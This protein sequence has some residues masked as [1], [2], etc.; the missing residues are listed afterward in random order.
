V[1]DL[2]LEDLEVVGS[3]YTGE[4]NGAQ[5]EVNV[6]EAPL[7]DCDHLEIRRAH[8]DYQID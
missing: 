2:E 1:E 8:V 5:I 6:V 7:G 3:Y 4:R